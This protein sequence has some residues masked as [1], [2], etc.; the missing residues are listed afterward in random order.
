MTG[1]VVQ[2]IAIDAGARIKSV[3]AANPVPACGMQMP[4]EAY[5]FFKASVTDDEMYRGLL[6]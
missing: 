1:M 2:R 3:V 6:G 5:G 4:E